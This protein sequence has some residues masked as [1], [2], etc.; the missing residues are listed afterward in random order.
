MKKAEFWESI[1]CLFTSQLHSF[2][3]NRRYQC[4]LL[5]HREPAL[6]HRSIQIGKSRCMPVDRYSCYRWDRHKRIHRS[7]KLRLLRYIL[8]R[9]KR[10]LWSWILL[11]LQLYSPCTVLGHWSTA[12]QVPSEPLTNPFLQEHPGWQTKVGQGVLLC[13]SHVGSHGLMQFGSSF[14]PQLLLGQL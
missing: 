5:V 11:K 9:Q 1:G 6:V 8:V 14:T 4:K 7:W 2:K 13:S 3:D 10:K 12:T